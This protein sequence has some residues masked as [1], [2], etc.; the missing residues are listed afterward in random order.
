MQKEKRGPEREQG[1]EPEPQT[2]PEPEPQ[3]RS[4]CRSREPGRPLFS[5]PS[6]W[7]G[8]GIDL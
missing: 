7:A 6:A 2:E 8:L 3:I 1:Q 5:E 4:R